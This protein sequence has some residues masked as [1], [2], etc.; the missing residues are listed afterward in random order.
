M[1]SKGRTRREGRPMSEASW[2]ESQ[3]EHQD[4]GMLPVFGRGLCRM[5]HLPWRTSFSHQSKDRTRRWC[6]ML[7]GGRSLLEQRG[8]EIGKDL[9]ASLKPRKRA[10]HAVSRKLEVDSFKDQKRTC[11]VW[12]CGHFT[13]LISSSL[14]GAP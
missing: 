14:S 5:S 6:T 2:L 3:E 10:A 11:C 13:C 4:L 12:V 8:V 9:R 7:Q 1:M